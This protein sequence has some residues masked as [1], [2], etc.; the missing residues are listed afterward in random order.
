MRY[1]QPFGTP[2]PPLGSYPRFINGNPVTGT[3]GSIPPAT[4]FDEDQIE[5]LNVITGAGI[6]PDHNDLTQLWQAI[7]GLIAQKYITTPIIKKVHGPGADF[8]DLTVAMVWLSQYI[9]TPSGSVTFMVAPGKWTYTQTVVIDHPNASRVTIQGGAL[10]GASPQPENI[11]CTGYH[12]AADG[13]NQIIYLRSVYATELSFTSGRTGFRIHVGGATLRYLLITGSQTVD[14]GG[15]PEIGGNGVLCFQHLMI[16]G[17]AI[18]GFGSFGLHMYG[19]E[20]YMMS[21]LSLTVCYCNSGIV[22]DGGYFGSEALCDVISAS[23]AGEGLWVRGGWA[24]MAI[25]TCQG[26]GDSGVLL[27][28][29]AFLAT[30]GP[31]SFVYNASCGVFMSG[32]TTLLAESATYDFNGSIGCYVSGGVAYINNSSLSGNGS[33]DLALAPGSTVTATGS[34]IGSNS[35]DFNTDGANMYIWY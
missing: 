28:S 30:T 23:N 11:S 2:T 24:V 5:I 4:A 35:P 26:N 14:N 16:D 20:V 29:G 3:E 10:L 15:W 8:V 33:L 7:Q 27:Y 31:S 32:A 1:S 13:T 9:I 21:S 22:L 12:Q 17:I 25:L 19:A 6:T 34:A 18:W